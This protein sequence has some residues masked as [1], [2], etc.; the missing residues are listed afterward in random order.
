MEIEEVMPVFFSYY[1]DIGILFP[2]MGAVDLT[3]TTVV[4]YRRAMKMYS[5]MI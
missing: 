5:S 1:S 3:V 4:Y 2:T